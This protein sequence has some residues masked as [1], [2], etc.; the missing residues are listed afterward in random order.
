MMGVEDNVVENGS[1]E[2]R[3]GRDS[4]SLLLFVV[5]CCCCC[6]LLL[7]S[8]LDAEP[9]RAHNAEC[10]VTVLIRSFNGGEEERAIPRGMRTKRM[11]KRAYASTDEIPGNVTFVCPIKILSVF[12]RHRREIR[13]DS[14]IIIRRTLLIAFSVSIIITPLSRAGIRLNRVINKRTDESLIGR[15]IIAVEE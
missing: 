9:N 7:V 13:F 1:R 14:T 5:C 12:S 8:F 10:T 6:L 3:V 2:G 15:K 11:Q 4:A